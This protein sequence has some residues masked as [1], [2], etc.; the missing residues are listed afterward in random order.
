MR[1]RIFLWSLFTAL[2]GFAFLESSPQAYPQAG[3]LSEQ[4]IETADGVK[5]H[6]TLYKA[7][8]SKNGSCVILLHQPGK[9]PTK[10]D[11][12]GLAKTLAK[13]GYHVLRFDFRGHGKS[14]EVIPEKF[15]KEQLNTTLASANKSVPPKKIDMKEFA[16]K[17]S[18]AP[19]LIYD[20]A[21]ARLALDKLNDDGQVNTSTVYI[22]G[23][24]DVAPLTMMF[25][26]SEWHRDA[27][28]PD[29]GILVNRS[30]VVTANTAIQ[31]D[32]KP[33]GRDYGGCVWLSPTLR[34]GFSFTKLKDLV[35]KVGMSRT[36]GALRTQT[37]MLFL[38]G[39]KDKEGEKNCK[40]FAENVMIAGG[41]R[42]D[43][44]EKL[45]S[46]YLRVIPATELKGV[47]L[48]GKDAELGTETLILEFL[49][50]MEEKR[51]NIVRTRRGYDEPVKIIFNS[52]ENIN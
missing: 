13:N 35:T 4:N 30:Q 3:D 8:N 39:E 28:K 1:R 9:D 7:Q 32:G 10:G 21:G 50:K 18:Y 31:A 43:A 14:T 11:W 17:S 38:H 15:W 24:A 52:F 25:L 49:K 26:A 2:S 27:K 45:D 40:N 22:I 34:P 5:L 37:P 19:Q 16:N 20:I 29:K 36:D 51:G 33:A 47:D 42:P 12:E 6:G 23:S 48:L 41:G 44:K 46:T